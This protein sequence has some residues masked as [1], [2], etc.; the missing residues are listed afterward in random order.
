MIVDVPSYFYR[1]SFHKRAVLHWLSKYLYDTADLSDEY[2]WDEWNGDVFDLKA[3]GIRSALSAKV[4]E[5]KLKGP[6]VYA[7]VGVDVSKLT[8]KQKIDIILDYSIYKPV[9]GKW[10]FEAESGIEGTEYLLKYQKDTA[11]KYHIVKYNAE[12]KTIK[13]LGA[14]SEVNGEL[15]NTFIRLVPAMWAD[16]RHWGIMLKHV[17]TAANLA[18][19]FDPE[20]FLHE[21]SAKDKSTYNAEGNNDKYASCQVDPDAGSS[22]TWLRNMAAA[23]YRQTQISLVVKWV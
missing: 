4:A 2:T 7:P 8:E 3:A 11:K 23:G 14:D 20:Y 12:K 21:W 15:L 1:G 13:F 18:N 9:T 6:G 22:L 5:G 17:K 19:D 16:K 10:T